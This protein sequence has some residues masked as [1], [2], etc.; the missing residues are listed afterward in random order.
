MWYLTEIRLTCYK[1]GLTNIPGKGVLSRGTNTMLLVQRGLVFVLIL[2][3][4]P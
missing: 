4:I 3:E 1:D 2:F